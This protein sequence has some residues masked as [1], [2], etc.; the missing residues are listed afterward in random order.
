VAV[1]TTARAVIRELTPED[2]PFIV[3]LLND[4]AFIRNIGDRGV[5]TDADAREYLAAGPLASYARHGFGLCAV[6]LAGTGAPI[7]ICGLLQRDELPGP[8]LGFA[9][10]PEFRA[11]GYAFEAASALRADAHARLGIRTL[12]AIVNPDNEPSIRLLDRLGF[13]RHGSIRL[14]GGTMDLALFVASLH[15]SLIPHP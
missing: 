12:H 11:R 8:D 13:A 9:F 4:P 1:L 3:T 7:G 10:L 2:A 14:S 6:T 15:E 5:R